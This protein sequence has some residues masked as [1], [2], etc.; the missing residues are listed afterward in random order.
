MTIPAGSEASFEI[1]LERWINPVDFG[2]YSGDH[3]IHAAGC[4][5]YTSPTEGITPADML[6]QVRGEGLNVGCVLTWGPCFEFQRRYFSPAADRLSDPF[7]VLKYDLEI[8]GFGSQALGHVC[9]LGLKDQT[10]PGSDGT[11]TRGWPTWTTPVLRWAKAQG[12]F[13]GYA[14]SASGLAI[15]PRSA[16]KRLLDRLDSGKDGFLGAQEAERGLLPED[17]S[18]IDADGDG[19]LS[20]AE[21][22]Q[23]HERAAEELPNLAIPEMNGVGAMEIPVSAAMG[24]CDFIS[25]MNTAR[26]Q[27]WNTWYH[28]L[29]CGLPVKVS[30]ETD[31][32]CMSGTRVGQGRVY[33][34]LGK[35]DRIEFQAWCEGLARGR[36]YVSDGYGHALEFT[37]EGHRPGEGAVMLDRAGSVIVKAK[38]AFSRETPLSVAQGGIVPREGKE[39]VGDT[40]LLH[41]SPLEGPSSGERYQGGRR[42]VEVVL[43]SIPIAG[44]EV[45][46]D[47][48]VH[49]LSFE[50]P[51]E[52]SAWIAL[53]QFPGLHTNPVEVLVAGKP[54]RASRK[55]ALW[56]IDVIDLLWQN[57]EA[58]I[59]GGERD[60]ARRTFQEAKEMY[61]GIASESPGIS[62]C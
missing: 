29:D 46:A 10:Y 24:A 36:S 52:R 48:E 14:H 25:A 12:G 47:G 15:E 11:K 7:T 17:F 2:F 5:H 32:P 41:G 59:A 39:L 40:V 27:E 22:V 42:S 44:A 30:G 54:I 9:L 53:R 31:F 61:R 37:V 28:L 18:A 3:H 50:V 38:V 23:S 35:V 8:S 34:R 58:A 56:L 57:R 6:L 43:N 21:L 45:P 60:E 19:L 1:K 20:E 16:A 51:V 26:I 13:T 55:S 4:A 49:D 62:R 33:V